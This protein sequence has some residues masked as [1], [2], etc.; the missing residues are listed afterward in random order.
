MTQM[1]SQEQ[2]VTGSLQLIMKANAF[3]IRND[4][5]FQLVSTRANCFNSLLSGIHAIS[6]NNMETKILKPNDPTQR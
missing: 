1:L 2:R 5:F 6:L 4:G 3:H